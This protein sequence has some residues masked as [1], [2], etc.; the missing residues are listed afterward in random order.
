MNRRTRSCEVRIP[1]P[2]SC[3]NVRKRRGQGPDT[4]PEHGGGAPFPRL[5]L[6]GDGLPGGANHGRE[7]CLADAARPPTHANLHIVVRGDARPGQRLPSV[8]A[9]HLSPKVAPAELLG[10]RQ[11]CAGPE[12]A[13]GG[14]GVERHRQAPVPRRRPQ[15]LDVHPDQQREHGHRKE[16]V[17]IAMRGERPGARHDLGRRCPPPGIPRPVRLGG[18]TEQGRTR[19]LRLPQRDPAFAQRAWLHDVTP[20]HRCRPP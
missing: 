2:C 12:A 14:P 13:K 17:I 8:G 10:R 7:L 6:I 3:S 18:H 16:R 11:G 5:P 9:P 1:P 15:R 20:C 4:T 19:R